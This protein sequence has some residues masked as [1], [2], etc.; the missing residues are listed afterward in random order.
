MSLIPGEDLTIEQVV[1]AMPANLKNAVTQSLVDTI[2]NIA[3]DPIL[4]ES[5]RNNFI[6]YTGVLKDGKFKAEDYLNAVMY[7]SYKLMGHTNQDAYA[8]TFPHRYQILVAKGTASKDIAAY[9]VA[10]NKGKLVNLV[11]EQTLVPTYVLNAHVYQEAINTQA[12]LMKNAFS[13]K[14]R[15]EA[16]NSILT[17]LKRPE[18][19]KG[20]LDI[21]VKDT[22]GVNELKNALRD[23]ALGQLKNIE[24]GGSVAQ[25]AASPIIEVEGKTVGTD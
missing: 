7:V 12:W 6:S 5:I 23:L 17:H 19:I 4:A 22:S 11:L 15:G 13:E 24:E 1:Q 16:A 20:T 14:V 3:A 8:K 10:Y 25:I 2:N 18:A 21:N 9:V